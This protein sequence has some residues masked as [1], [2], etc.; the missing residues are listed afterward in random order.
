LLLREPIYGI[1]GL[2]E[3]FANK[4]R[5]KPQTEKKV[6]QSLTY[7]ELEIKSKQL[8]TFVKWINETGLSHSLELL[9]VEANLLSAFIV[10][11]QVCIPLNL[12]ALIGGILFQQLSGFIGFSAINLLLSFCIGFF[13]WIYEKYYFRKHK[14]KSS[15]FLGEKFRESHPNLGK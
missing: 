7:S 14:K 13:S 5:K 12:V 2:N 11:C 1:D 4:F 6:A 8:A 9:N 3:R 10:A 15:S